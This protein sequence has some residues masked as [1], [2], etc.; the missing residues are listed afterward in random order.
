MA[1]TQWL[2]SIQRGRW[3]QHVAFT[4]MAGG[5]ARRGAIDRQEAYS[6]ADQSRRPIY[7]RYAFMSRRAIT[8]CTVVQCTTKAR[9][10]AAFYGHSLTYPDSLGV[11]TQYPG[12]PR[13]STG[14][15]ADHFSGPLHILSPFPSLPFSFPSLPPSPPFPSLPFHPPPLPHPLPSISFPPIPS[16]RSRPLKSS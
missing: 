7:S 14:P 5:A 6:A 13:A 1:D 3:I 8:S 2:C 15:G 10:P 4:V 16:L 11:A 9:P 12:P